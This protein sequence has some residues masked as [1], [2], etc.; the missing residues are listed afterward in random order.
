VYGIGRTLVETNQ[1]E[2]NLYDIGGVETNG[3]TAGSAWIG[4]AVIGQNLAVANDATI[5]SSL[6]VGEGGISTLGKLS[7]LSFDLA[8]VRLSNATQ[9][10]F[11]SFPTGVAVRSNIAYLADS[12]LYLVDVTNPGAP[13]LISSL[14]GFDGS[15]LVVSGDYVYAAAGIG[16]KIVDVS[17]PSAP[18]SVGYFSNGLSGSRPAIAGSYAYM[19][20]SDFQVVDISNPVS[21]TS[22]ATV[23]LTGSVSAPDVQSHY[24]YFGNNNT[25]FNVY[26]IADPRNPRAVGSLAGFTLIY[27]VKV[28]GRYAYVLDNLSVKVVDI[29]NPASPSLVATVTTDATVQ[30]NDLE[31]SGRYLYVS[32]HTSGVDVY[33]ISTPSSPTKISAAVTAGAAFGIAPSGKYLFVADFASGLTVLD[34]GGAD[35]SSAKIGQVEIGSGAVLNNL[36]IGG[37]LNVNGGLLVGK[38]GIYSQGLITGSSLLV[39]ANAFTTSSQLSLSGTFTSIAVHNE[40]AAILNGSIISSDIRLV[41]VSDPT[42]SYTPTACVWKMPT[43]V[44]PWYRKKSNQEKPL[45][46]N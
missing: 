37:Q 33:D 44:L 28:M 39:S 25:T 21:P 6:R 42:N 41:D 18:T 9:T 8:H 43:M 5:G 35:I 32:K 15:D 1:D 12:S 4:N 22:V 13:S 46:I 30:L 26:D 11:S 29:S 16:L 34:M 40:I 2:I 23:V 24:A 45:F 17:N 38:E 20:G 7:A 31:I 27:R 14:S 19:G 36:D 10:H 3:L